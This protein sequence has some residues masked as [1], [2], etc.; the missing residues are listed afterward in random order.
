MVGVYILGGII[1]VDIST[2]CVCNLIDN[3]VITVNGNGVV[4]QIILVLI[5][6]IKVYVFIAI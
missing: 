4:I 2:S 5:D 1:L 6:I 3:V